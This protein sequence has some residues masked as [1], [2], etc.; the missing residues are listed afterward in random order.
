MRQLQGE[1]RM[2]VVRATGYRRQSLGPSQSE[3]VTLTPIDTLWSLK[4]THKV[5]W[6]VGKDVPIYAYQAQE[7]KRSLLVLAY[8]VYIYIKKN[9][10]PEDSLS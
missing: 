10:S 2:W 1:L 5:K 9:I 3:N 7:T 8:T 4:G 6:R